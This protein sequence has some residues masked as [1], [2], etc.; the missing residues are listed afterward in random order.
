MGVVSSDLLTGRFRPHGTPERYTQATKFRCEQTAA[1]FECLVPDS[2]SDVRK[3]VAHKLIPRRV[4]VKLLKAADNPA[5]LQ[6]TRGQR[7]HQI[8]ASTN[9]RQPCLARLVRARQISL[10][11]TLGEEREHARS[12]TE[13]LFRVLS[14]G[15]SDEDAPRRASLRSRPS[16]QRLIASQLNSFADCFTL[17]GPRASENASHGRAPRFQAVSCD[18]R[19]FKAGD[20][21]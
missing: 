10:D 13:H 6:L 3:G 17:T 15:L 16:H 8:N 7:L 4:S 1:A 19:S 9:A 21:R 5:L 20:T 2:R 14:H 18:L 11:S 12:A